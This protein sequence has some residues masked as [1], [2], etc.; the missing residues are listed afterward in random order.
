MK[1][2]VIRQHNQADCGLA[3]LAMIAGAHG[4]HQDVPQLKARFGSSDSG[5]G[6][7]RLM[8]A[9]RMLALDSRALKLDI[10][11]ARQLRTPAILIWG[12]NH[13]V[14]LRRVTRRSWSIIDP[15]RGLCRCNLAEVNRRFSGIALEMFPANNFQRQSRPPGL[16]LVH[17]WAGRKGIW[18]SV[19]VILLL[20]ASLQVMSLLSPLYIQLV[21]DHGL[22]RHDREL[23]PLLAL[24]FGAL[25]V[26]GVAT[27]FTRSMLV[28]LAGNQLTQYFSS[29]FHHH[30]LRLPLRYFLD[31]DIGDIM[32]RFGSL[33][34]V[35]KLFTTGIVTAIIDGVLAFATVFLLFAY[36]PVLAAV[37]IMALLVQVIIQ[38]LVLPGMRIRTE[39]AI[40]AGANEKTAFIESLRSIISLKANAMER[41]RHLFWHN[42]LCSS[43]SASSR[44]ATLEIRVDTVLNLLASL[45]IILVIYLGALAVLQAEMT[46]GMLYALVA[47]RNHFT[48]AARRLLAEIVD[49]RMLKLHLSRLGDIALT[50]PEPE[51]GTDCDENTVAGA[52]RLE[53]V[54]FAYGADQTPVLKEIDLAVPE[55]AQ[56]G[57]VGDSAAGKTTLL[58]LILGLLR[59]THGKIV[60]PGTD[61]QHATGEHVRRQIGVVMQG[62]TLFTGSVAENVALFALEADRDRVAACCALSGVVADIEALPL[63]YETRIGDMGAML[64]AGQVQRLLIARALYKKPRIL[65]LD[66]ATANLDAR[67]RAQVNE[68]LRRLGVTIIRVT[69]QEDELGFCDRVYAL[70]A[71]R[72]V[73]RDREYTPHASRGDD[74]S[75]G[76]G[77]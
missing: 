23:I 38:M 54:S 1:I 19:A 2:P 6:L 63:K 3:C 67:S 65:V 44:L 37:I 50:A 64:S 45:E 39:D 43:I 58:K 21:V 74:G 34:P 41:S 29:S 32:A 42:R 5:W 55:G 40:H 35:L 28:L 15:A 13:Y 77:G 66:E 76:A 24:G 59:P 56:I 36:S 17:L 25:A 62:D 18:S 68:N 46:I 33:D 61:R 70:R 4:N 26:L 75:G 7:H 14:V 11:E 10:H 48:G 20:S 53:D 52:L 60:F 47:Y 30:L 9:G 51:D 73:D 49:F 16:R 27:G 69:H 57:I 22:A 71:G 72:L 31:R 8:D 12:A